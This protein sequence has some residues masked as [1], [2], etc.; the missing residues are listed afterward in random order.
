MQIHG[1]LKGKTVEYVATNGHILV[2]RCEDGRELQIAWV[3]DNGT[4]IMGK[5]MLRFCG[6]NIITRLQR[7]KEIEHRVEV[8][9]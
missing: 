2:V 6:T 5:P 9:V 8:G 4:P 3:D 1:Q 7:V